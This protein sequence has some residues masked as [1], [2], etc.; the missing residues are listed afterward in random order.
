MIPE[1]GSRSEAW[2]VSKP[3]R[4][5]EL[6]K[7]ALREIRR[8]GAVGAATGAPVTKAQELVIILAIRQY[9]IERTEGAKRTLDAKDQSPAP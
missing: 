6:A 8:I 3:D 7:E 4:A 1:M 5:A 2:G 9:Y